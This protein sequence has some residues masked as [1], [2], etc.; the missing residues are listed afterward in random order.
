MNKTISLICLFV[1][2]ALLS[3]CVS[4][5]VSTGAENRGGDTKNKSYG[6][7]QHSKVVEKKIIWFWQEDFRKPQ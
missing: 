5:T 3:G 2:T 1:L 6:S 7:E 4:R